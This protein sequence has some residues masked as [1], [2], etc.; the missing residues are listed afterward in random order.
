M[1]SNKYYK[2]NFYKSRDSNTKE[3]A[4]QILQLLFN[5]FKPKSMVDFGC[6]VGTWVKIGQ[7]LGVQEILGLE[8]N[9]L[10]KS[11]LVIPE[12]SFQHKDLTTSFILNK[13][14]DLAISLEVAEHINEKYSTNFINNLT[15]ASKIILFSA[16]IPG[17]RGAGHVNEQWPEYWIEKFKSKGYV[18]LDLIRPYIWD[19]NDIKSW[20]KQN[21]LVFIDKNKLEELPV[22]LKFI[23][24]KKKM[25]A[26]VHPDTFKRQ[27]D[28]SHPRF[29]TLPKVLGSIP[30]LSFNAIKN[31]AKKALNR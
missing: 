11:H 9:W 28:I 24:E 26:I 30:R 1:K 19:N 7:E 12:S 25:W 15:S 18:A 3:S 22:L 29:S 4:S 5:Y 27:I 31:L 17:Q 21:T 20:Y 10:D 8:G 13:E 23:D 6:G 2:D 16:A 14:Y